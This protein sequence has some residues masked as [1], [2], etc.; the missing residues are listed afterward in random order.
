MKTR[1]L[2]AIGLA[3][4][5]LALAAAEPV[6]VTPSP[7]PAPST[8]PARPPLPS[9]PNVLRIPRAPRAWLGLDLVKPDASI[10]AQLPSLPPGIGFVIS[11]VE[12]DG[13]GEAAGLAEFDVVWKFND[14]FLVNESQLAALL[15][16]SKPGED[17]TLSGFRAGKPFDLKLKLGEA[18]I[19]LKPFSPEMLESSVFPGAHCGGMVREIN[20]GNK[21]ATYTNEEGRA[22]VSKPGEGYMV[23]ITKAQGEVVFEGELKTDADYEKV[24]HAWKHRIHALRR[25]LDLALEGR[26]MVPARQP[27]PRVVP[28]AGK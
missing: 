26:S 28:P 18:P 3:F 16:I 17:V 2:T 20:I 7:A 4:C 10:T 14:Q 11:T 27:R 24:P 22:E 8:L 23:K 25:G 5:L 13:P 21:T 1:P 15:R 9:P 19:N 12:K 6:A